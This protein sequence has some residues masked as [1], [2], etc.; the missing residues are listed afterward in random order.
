[1]EKNRKLVIV[2]TTVALII[3]S[4]ILVLKNNCNRYIEV[5]YYGDNSASYEGDEVEAYFLYGDGDLQEGVVTTKI[6]RRHCSFEIPK[7]VNELQEIQIR[8]A[9]TFEEVG[10]DRIVI[11]DG[12]FTVFSYSGNELEQMGNFIGKTRLVGD[13]SYVIVEAVDNKLQYSFDKSVLKQ[14]SGVLDKGSNEVISRVFL[15]TVFALL[16][17][18][19]LIYSTKHDALLWYYVMSCVAIGA[20]FCVLSM[21]LCSKTFGHPDEDVTRYAIDYYSTHWSIPDVRDKEI[22]NTFSNYGYTRLMETTVYYMIAGKITNFIYHFFHFSSYYR[23][24]NVV[25]Y[26]LICLIAMYWGRKNTVMFLPAIISP[27]V[28]YIFSYATSDA[29]DYFLSYVIIGELLVKDSIINKV[30]ASEEKKRNRYI[31]HALFGILL[32]LL[33]LGKK[34]YYEVL[35]LACCCF[36][37]K[38]YRMD[39]QGRLRLLKESIIVFLFFSVAVLGRIAFDYSIYKGEKAEIYAEVRAFHRN[40]ESVKRATTYKQKGYSIFEAYKE[41]GKKFA[42]SSFHSFVGRYGWMD[43]YS[44]ERYYQLMIVLYSGVLFLLFISDFFFI[45]KERIIKSVYYIQI[46]LSYFISVYHAWS[47][48]WQPQ[49]RYLFPVIFVVVAILN[50]NYYLNNKNRFRMILY[51]VLCG[52][53]FAGW[54]SFIRYGMYGVIAV[55]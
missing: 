44:G 38:V 30:L 5:F 31:I 7:D 12:I 33:F 48:D 40:E 28:W 49:G 26:F 45:R 32:A 19:Y 25:L 37:Y 29:W 53:G 35:L 18:L 13:G 23:F 46:A 8:L 39:H 52:I 3:L 21:A 43:I 36:F 50:M 55:I 41:A 47:A 51:F 27:Q 24:F 42:R 20:F 10:I 1:M 22:Y 54:Y 2:A 34:N 16:I 6:F 9:S 17:I 4:I 11:R 15:G 14:I